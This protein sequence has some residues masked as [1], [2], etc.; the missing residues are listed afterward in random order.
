MRWSVPGFAVALVGVS[1][2]PNLPALTLILAVAAAI[3][4]VIDVGM[5]AHGV[6]VEGLLDRPILS[7]LHAMH[8]LGGMAA[9]GIAAAFAWVEIGTLPHF[10]SV[11]VLAAAIGVFATGGLL[12]PE[13]ERDEQDDESRSVRGW[14][15]G[16]SRPVFY[17]G[18]LAFC[19]TLVEG[20]LLDWGA[21]FLRDERGASEGLS[22]AGVTAFLAGIMLGRLAGDW[23]IE[24]FGPLRTFRAG[25]ALALAIDRPYLAL[26]G[27]ALVGAGISCLLPLL[28]SVAGKLGNGQ[29]PAALVARISTL[30]YLGSFVGPGLIGVLAGVVGLVGALLL[31]A[32]LLVLAVLGTTRIRL[33]RAQA[34]SAPG[35]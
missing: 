23:A 8:P 16:W 29:T 24:R 27:V 32:A 13:G 5:N 4:S 28:F 19:V 30:G 34:E 9:G 2:A 18:L 15:R 33:E 17:L 6:R 20:G 21:V 7:G 31:P 10:A 3:N 22:A 1:L 12:G 25:G 11:A 26:A 35:E 14:F